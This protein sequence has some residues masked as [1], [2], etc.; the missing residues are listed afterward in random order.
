MSIAGRSPPGLNVTWRYDWACLLTYSQQA[1]LFA[2]SNCAFGFD[3]VA[4]FAVSEGIF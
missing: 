1:L 2:V 4:Q 3:L